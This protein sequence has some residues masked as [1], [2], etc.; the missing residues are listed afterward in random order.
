MEAVGGWRSDGAGAGVCVFSDQPLTA[1]R[2]PLRFL[3]ILA[4]DPL[5]F[6]L[7]RFEFSLRARKKYG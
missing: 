5:A 1:N 7:R 3:D 2:Q 6:A 4:S